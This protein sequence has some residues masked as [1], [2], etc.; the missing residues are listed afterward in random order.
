MNR[1]DAVKALLD[2]PS[3][4]RTKGGDT[5]GLKPCTF[6]GHEAAMQTVTTAMEKE[7]RYR[8]IC[9]MCRIATD[10]DFWKPEDVAA[11]WNRRVNDG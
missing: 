6:C 9:P 3:D 2:I 1:D 4:R 11:Q 7:P 5:M 10:W 8:V